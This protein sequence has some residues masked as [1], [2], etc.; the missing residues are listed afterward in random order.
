LT[1]AFNNTYLSNIITNIVPGTVYI[2][3]AELGKSPYNYWLDNEP[4]DLDRMC[5]L[6]KPWLL[7]KPKLRIATQYTD[8]LSTVDENF[9]SWWEQ[10]ESDW[11]RHWR[12]DAWPIEFIRG[13]IQVGTVKELDT[14]IS[15][16][17][18]QIPVERI[19][20]R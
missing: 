17:Q 5:K 13:V 4:D 6:A 9:Y 14:M 1:K 19:T 15:L 20:L 8:L 12:L 16:F 2:E 11:C 7:F 3:W 18:Q 10:Y